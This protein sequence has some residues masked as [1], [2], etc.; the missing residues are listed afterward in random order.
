LSIRNA[1]AELAMLLALSACSGSDPVPAAGGS[2]VR[3][4]VTE[5]R[6]GGQYRQELASHVDGVPIV[7]EVFEPTH[8]VAGASYPLVLQGEGFGDKRI[9]SRTGF[10]KR[11]VDA[12]YYVVT[13]DHRGFGES[14]GT[15]RLQSPDFEGQDLIQVLDWAEDLPG[16]RRRS[17]GKMLV[18]SYGDSYGGLYQFLL[19]GA[20]PQHRL[21]VLAPDITPHD[22]VAVTNPNN[23]L[24]SGYSL[25][26]AAQG[27]LSQVTNGQLLTRPGPGMDLA[28][29]ETLVGAAVTNNMTEAGRNFLRYHSPK[30]FC[31]GEPAGPQ[32]FI[33]ATPDPRKVPPT[34]YEPLD[35]LLTQG[36]RDTFFNVNEALENFR[37]VEATGGDVRLLTHETGHILPI[38]ITAAPG[39]LEEALD[40]FFV[41]I[42]PPN[43]QDAD[44]IGQ[45]FCGSLDLLDVQFA[46]FEE[47]LQ[48]KA[49]AIDA[50][51][52]TGHDICWSLGLDDAIVVHEA[53]RGGQEF[54]I[55]DATPQFNSAL[56]V[57]GSVLGNGER[58]ALLATQRLYTAPAGGAII[59]GVP[60][61]DLALG[62]VGGVEMPECL[63]PP[64]PAAC[65]PILFLGIGHRH[66]GATRWDLV[67]DQLTPVRGFGAHV[68]DM[69]AVGERLA[70][71]DELAL[72]IYGFNAQY[73]VTWSRDLLVPATEVSGKVSLPL[74]TAG[75][76][77]SR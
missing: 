22:I 45:R 76:V 68:G 34:P 72:L 14:G 37:C 73:P 13:I 39:N 21:R 58:E 77:V 8:L 65:D 49:G 23:V 28:V 50:A 48:G 66:A 9:T 70:E 18:G 63:L 43:F 26:V 12:G 36:M 31:D 38:S 4:A 25:A 44:R 47:E 42:Y 19:A 57:I 17:N 52:P 11:L 30:Y 29:Y 55:D 60:T 74:M 7:F 15:I 24:K 2:D 64:L 1:V 10:V 51:L 69:S 20:D 6:D 35:V 75:E 3:V 33:L 61:M 40:P 46:W 27:E 67:D 41:A 56:G 32:D 16:L 5:T 71:G 54:A 59:A 53:K 62:G